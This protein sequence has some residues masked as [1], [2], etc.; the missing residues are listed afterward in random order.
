M[1]NVVFLAIREENP[2]S[3]YFDHG[4]ITRLVE[5]FDHIKYMSRIMPDGLGGA[6]VIIPARNQASDINEINTELNKLKWA[7]IV[8]TGDEESVFPFEKINHPNCKIWV[9]SPKQGRHDNC[10]FKLGSG[11][12]YDQPQINKEVTTIDPRNLDFF[13]SGQITH[14]KRY[15]MADALR[16]VPGGVF[17]EQKGFTQGLDLPEYLGYLRSARFAPAPAGP[18]S[19]DNF[20]L[21]E[22][23]E[24]GAI[25]IGDGGDY[26]N[27]LF[28]E[29][30]PF[31]IIND[32]SEVR[33]I[34]SNNMPNWLPL[35]NK[36]FAWWQLYKCKM[37]RKLQEDIRAVSGS[38]PSYCDEDLTVIM[39]TSSIPSHPSTEMIER[40]IASVRDRLPNVE[41]FLTIDGF[42]KDSSDN[43]DNYNEYIR[44]LLWKLNNKYE[45]IVPILMEK[46][47]HQTTMTK[48][49]FKYV[50]TP[51]ILYVEHDTPLEN[52]IPFDNLVEVIKSGNAN[53]I[54]LN[55]FDRVIEEH[56][57]LQLDNAE[58]IE[59]L[60]VPLIRSIQWSQRP[61]LVSTEY[62]KKCSVKYWKDR[63]FIEH[64]M[65]GVVVHEPFEYHK[66]HIY[67]PS[68]ETGMYRSGNL[69]GR[70]YKASDK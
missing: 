55:H 5:S 31:P 53:A 44:R 46:F 17:L 65:Y 26:W 59:V 56:K 70:M 23:L 69:N 7:V 34:I 52:N 32:W 50:N 25:P 19:P 37:K 43:K 67:A 48:E 68:G 36:V 61:H 54:R 40:T 62:Y 39:S 16:G 28:G 10:S 63:M 35:S 49:A 58:P 20:R 11:F 64:C 4:L 12:R 3:S 66:L 41:I 6:V 24:T 22:A 60:G 14:E 33:H 8:L 21:Y 30:V 57:Y 51:T 47:S 2:P 42:N 9:M 18:V 29:Q 38:Y 27:Y 1:L 13:F 15:K 45:N